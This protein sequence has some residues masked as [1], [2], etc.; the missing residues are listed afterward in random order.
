M[1][2]WQNGFTILLWQ[3][4]CLAVDVQLKLPVQSYVMVLEHRDLHSLNHASQ[5]SVA[6]G[7]YCCCIAEC[8]NECL[9]IPLSGDS[10]LQLLK[11]HGGDAG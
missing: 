1:C 11:H 2:F 8:A 5:K 7:N 3:E 10:L 4:T 9:Y 6:W